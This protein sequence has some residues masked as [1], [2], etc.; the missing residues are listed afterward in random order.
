[1]AT[2]TTQ[3]KPQREEKMREKM[4]YERAMEQLQ[5]LLYT[6]NSSPQQKEQG[7]E[8]KIFEELLDKNFPI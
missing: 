5:A 6:Y 1:M 8:W 4:N 3:N 2:E 7:V